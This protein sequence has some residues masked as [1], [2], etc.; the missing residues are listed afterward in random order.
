VLDRRKNNF[1]LK[2]I[3]PLCKPE[4]NFQSSPA[5]DLSLAWTYPSC[6]LQ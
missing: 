2:M 6:L 1:E 5:A 3:L 4:H